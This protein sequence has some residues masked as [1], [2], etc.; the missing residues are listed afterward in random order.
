[1]VKFFL[2][3]YLLLENDCYLKFFYMYV[4]AKLID[5]AFYKFVQL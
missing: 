1:M 3:L 5:E 4:L 2:C